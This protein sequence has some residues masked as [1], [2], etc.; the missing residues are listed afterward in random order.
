MAQGIVLTEEEIEYILS[1]F[2]KGWPERKVAAMSGFN[3]KTVVKVKNGTIRRIKEGDSKRITGH[4]L[5]KYVSPIDDEVLYLRTNSHGYLCLAGSEDTLHY[6]E[7]KKVFRLLDL[8][9]PQDARVHHIDLEK[10]SYGL[11]NLHVFPNQ[12]MH[13]SYHVGLGKAMYDFLFSNNLLESFY[14]EYPTLKL[15]TLSDLIL[16]CLKELKE[17]Q[18]TT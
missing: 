14:E 3:R 15:L 10:R 16:D 9:W 12:L 18:P 5:M 7:A 13:Q 17:E 1:L 2:K 8:P 4:E 6:Y 11:S